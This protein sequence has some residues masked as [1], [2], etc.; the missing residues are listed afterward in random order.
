MAACSGVFSVTVLNRFFFKLK[1]ISLK[2][3]RCWF[4]LCWYFCLPT[5]Y[6]LA[7]V[8]S[9]I[10]YQVKVA[11]I[12]NFIAFTHWPEIPEQT[13]YLCIYGD[14][15]FGSEIDKLEGKTVH[16]LRLK[17]ERT[18]NPDKLK[19]CQVIFFSKAL[20]DRLL[21]VLNKLEGLPILT[22]ADNPDAIAQGVVINMQL[23]QEKIVFEINLNVARKSG[24][25]INSRLLQLAVK[26]H[27]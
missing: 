4:V 22:L 27:Q 18:D 20:G 26:V 23:A 11:F 17:I 25:D 3:S 7:Q 21:N 1:T 12:Y 16:G 10:E 8:E 14:D 19:A 9:A 5:P 2:R 24:L 15:H 6:A 13:I